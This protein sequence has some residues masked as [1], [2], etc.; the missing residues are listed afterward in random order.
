MP[1]PTRLFQ[2]SGQTLPGLRV[3]GNT[4]FRDGLLPTGDTLQDSHAPLHE[5]VGLDIDKIGTRQPMLG[6]E[7]GFLVPLDIRKQLGG[8]TLEGS[9][10]FSAH[11]VT[12]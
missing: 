2:P 7:D 11:E 9:D 12:L 10:K 6:D 1:V 8:L 3:G 5:L 4:P